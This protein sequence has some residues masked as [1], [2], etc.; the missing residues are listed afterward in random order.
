MEMKSIVDSHSEE[1]KYQK[2][3]VKPS[4]TEII[5]MEPQKVLGENSTKNIPIC[6]VFAIYVICV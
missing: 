5:N 4:N 6:A 1:L 3:V 2:N